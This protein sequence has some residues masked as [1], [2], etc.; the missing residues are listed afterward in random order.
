MYS[1]DDT[2][3][4]VLRFYQEVIRHPYLND[5]ALIIPPPTGWDSIKIQG[6]NETVLDL[7]RHLPYLRSENQY[8]RLLVHWE[9][10][11]VCYP[12]TQN[13]QEVYPLPAY[14]VYL[15]HSVDREGTSL[16]LDTNK[17][18]TTEYTHTGSHI[19]V[20]CEEYDALPESDK[21]KVH[22]T[23]PITEFFDSW[24]RKYE[25][26]VWMLVPNPIGQPTTGRFYSR[27]ETRVEEEELVEQGLPEPWHPVDDTSGNDHGDESEL[28]REHRKTR[29][30]ARKHAADVYNTYLR[31]GWP[32]HFDKQRCRAE[33]LE[34][35]KI[36]DADD[37]RWMDEMN[38]D[39]ALFG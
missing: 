1:R 36:K 39:A 7:L 5:N 28:D 19:I 38:P 21:W 11:P 31:Y 17:G 27:A 25:K 16:I 18:T 37:R 9:T 10:V 6:K 26:L 22:R 34:L 12:D 35:E 20:S 8:R 3:R 30:R 33:L 29:A 23:S 4:A 15:T 24:T 32:D 13:S 14:C 2:A